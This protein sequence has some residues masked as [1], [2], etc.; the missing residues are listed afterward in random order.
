VKITN[1]KLPITLFALFLSL[2]SGQV[3]ANDSVEGKITTVE[4]CSQTKEAGV[5]TSVKDRD[6]KCQRIQSPLNTNCLLSIDNI[7]RPKKIMANLSGTNLK[8]FKGGL[9]LYEK[10]RQVGAYRRKPGI[11][12]KNLDADHQIEILLE[13]ANTDQ[14][15][16]LTEAIIYLD[17]SEKGKRLYW[18]QYSCEF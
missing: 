12:S 8:T 10:L 15:H 13:R 11:F 16:Q 7:D 6:L 3:F 4:Q 14:E 5:F 2:Q 1:T 17:H 9:F 18:T